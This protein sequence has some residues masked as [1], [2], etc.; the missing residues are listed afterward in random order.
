MNMAKKTLTS[1]KGRIEIENSNVK[2]FLGKNGKI[3]SSEDIYKELKNYDGIKKRKIFIILV[4]K[5]IL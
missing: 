4:K 5:H 3:K 1:D 2:C